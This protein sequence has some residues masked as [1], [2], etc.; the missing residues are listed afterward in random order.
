MAK[1]V[2]DIIPPKLAKKIEEDVREYLKEERKRVMRQSIDRSVSRHKQQKRPVWFK[3]LIGGIAALFI[4]GVYL[5]FKLPKANVEIWP[6]V[7][8][9]SFQQEITAD[10]K[11]SL[12]DIAEN[13]IPAGRFEISKTLSENFPATGS[14]SD[15][16]RA[17]GIITIYNK[18]DPSQ[19]ITLKAGTH[20]LSD[21]GKLF[22]APDRIVVPAAKKSGGKITPGSVQ[23]KVRAVEGGEGYNIP[24]SN[25]SIP[26]LKGTAFYYTVYASSNSEMTGGYT[27]DIKKVIDDDIQSAENVLI[28]KLK[29]QASYDLEQQISSDYV[30]P[31]GATSFQITSAGAQTESGTI[32]DSFTYEA[33]IK[34]SAVTFK[35]SDLEEFAKKYIISQMSKGKT[36][37]ESSLKLDYSI[38]SADMEKGRI[39]ISLNFSSGIYKSIDKNSISIALTG[40]NASQISQTV[41]SILGQELSKTEIKFWPFWVSKAPRNQKAVNVFLKFE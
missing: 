22:R 2:Y 41:N 14:A 5:F 19:S 21:S 33:T 34:F 18:F 13:V 31:S 28:D 23:V 12:T 16:G 30:I 3:V 27:G 37:L 8:T 26:G 39:A 11:A 25:F 24:A 36:M 4:I 9:L 17:S 35:K 32:T 40:K 10:V 1:K 29:E 38:S 20:F 15:E 7:E 6:K